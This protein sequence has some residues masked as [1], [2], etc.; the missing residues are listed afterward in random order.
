METLQ[1]FKIIVCTAV[2]VFAVI[3]DLKTAK[4]KNPI[5]VMGLSIGLI[6]ALIDA[7]W[8]G[9]LV[10]LISIMAAFAFGLPLY[11][12]KMFTG[13]DF[14]L[15]MAVSAFLTWQKAI[16]T[17]GASLVW[18]ALFGLFVILL[19][20]RLKTAA[21]NINLVLLTRKSLESD[22]ATKIPFSVALAFGYASSFW[23]EQFW[24]ML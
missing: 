13:G 4:I 1:I 15:L 23:S 21:A 5:F 10:S 20:G 17:V 18:G 2:L 12:M 6:L 7:G 3:Q 14:K 8:S 9:L 22:Q 24:S 16:V 19:K 11:L